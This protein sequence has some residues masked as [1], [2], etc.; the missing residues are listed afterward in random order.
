MTKNMKRVVFM[1]L[2]VMT[3]SYYIGQTGRTF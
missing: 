1:E 2:N 3:D